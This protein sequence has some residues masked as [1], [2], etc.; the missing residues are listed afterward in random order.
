MVAEIENTVVL[1]S[2]GL[3][4]TVLL[5]LCR[6]AFGNVVAMHFSYGSKHNSR[7]KAAATAIC[8][9]TKIKLIFIDLPFINELFES[10]LL[11]SGGEIPEGYY[12]EENMKKTV[13]PFRNGIMLSI[14]TGYAGSIGAQRVAIA[15]HHG[16]HAIYPDCRGVFLSRMQDTMV[17]GLGRRI[18]LFAPFFPLSKAALVQI[19]V[20][21][22]VPFEMTYSCYKGGEKHCGKCGTCMERKEAFKDAGVPD[23]TI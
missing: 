22:G 2:G 11:E 4:S 17:L 13:V 1:Y 18:Q 7:E 5:Y 19:G 21:L 15:A 16:D 14:A 8:A 3:D 23:P 6:K 10:D 20:S 12:T 9:K